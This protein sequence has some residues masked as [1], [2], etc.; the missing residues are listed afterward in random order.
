MSP[1]GPAIARMPTASE[2][3]GLYRES[4]AAPASSAAAPPSRAPHPAA[5]AA[6]AP[7]ARPATRSSAPSCARMREENEHLGILD[8]IDPLYLTPCPQPALISDHNFKLSVPGARHRHVQA[9]C[10]GLSMEFEVFEWAEGG[11][12]EFI[13]HLPGRLPLPV[14]ALTGGLTGPRT[15]LQKW[16]WK[17]R[18]KAELKEI[19]IELQSQD[20][21]D[22][23]LVDVRR[24]LPDQWSG[25]TIAAAS[26]AMAEEVLEIAHSGLKMG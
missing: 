7:A 4:A 12:N 19:T 1:T 21:D 18:E 22:D 16:F 13:H 25:P 10:D 20:G 2:A 17:T 23:P 26:A 6:A 11:N 24:R 14:P 9:S 5:V 8:G 3:T 15:T